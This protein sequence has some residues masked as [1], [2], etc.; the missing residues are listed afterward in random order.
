MV[1]IEKGTYLVAINHGIIIDPCNRER[2]IIFTLDSVPVWLAIDVF[3]FV[4]LLPEDG[5]MLEQLL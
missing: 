5:S 3:R 2:L 4:E 1:N